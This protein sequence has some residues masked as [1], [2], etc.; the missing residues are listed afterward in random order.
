MAY[1]QQEQLQEALRVIEEEKI[2]FFEEIT[3]YVAPSKRIMQEW[4]FHELPTIKDALDRN[5]IKGKSKLRNKWQDSGNATLELAAY[6][7]M[8]TTEELERLT[9]N[10]NKNQ[11]S[12]ELNVNGVNLI[13]EK[14]T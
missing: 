12:G 7:L 5:K 8:A 1:D 4:G 10:N 2:C 6:K 14:A 13:F 11:S 3:L 9:V